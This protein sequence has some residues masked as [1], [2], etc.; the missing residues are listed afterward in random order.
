MITICEDIDNYQ[1][2]VSFM[3]KLRFFEEYF[4]DNHNKMK[5]F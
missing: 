1:H 3:K 2:I 4:L 5:A